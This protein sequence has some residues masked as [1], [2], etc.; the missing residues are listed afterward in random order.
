MKEHTNGLRHTH[1]IPIK[2]YRFQSYNSLSYDRMKHQHNEAPY[3]MARQLRPLV[4]RFMDPTSG[5]SRADRTQVGPTLA[6]WI[7]LSG[8]FYNVYLTVNLINSCEICAI[9]RTKVA[10]PTRVLLL[11]CVKIPLS[12]HIHMINCIKL[13]IRFDNFVTFCKCINGVTS[14]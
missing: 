6:Q 11:I 13:N 9:Q 10:K 8:A 3:V 4:A 12:I 5:S 2:P 7:S 1:N 14:R